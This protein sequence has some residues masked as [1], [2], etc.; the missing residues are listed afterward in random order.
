MPDAVNKIRSSLQ[1]V[2]NL[3]AA[4]EEI[5]QRS[6]LSAKIANHSKLFLEGKI[7]GGEFL[8]LAE[9]TE[10]DIDRYVD[11]IETNLSEIGFFL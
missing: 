2:I 5:E 9:S 6:I 1:I 4:T 7:S 3:E 8:D 11:E 10:I